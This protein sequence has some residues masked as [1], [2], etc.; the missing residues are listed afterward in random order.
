MSGQGQNE[1]FSKFWGGTNPFSSPSNQTQQPSPTGG[2]PYDGKGPNQSWGPNSFPAINPVGSINPGWPT[3]QVQGD[4]F[5]PSPIGSSPYDGKG[6]NQSWG[7]NSFPAIDP[8]G[9]INPGQ[10]TGSGQA[11]QPVNPS[12]GNIGSGSNPFR[13]RWGA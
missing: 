12:W 2:S 11:Q 6:P 13:G 4:A 3:G 10:P 1:N 9:I 5:P 7:P 8:F